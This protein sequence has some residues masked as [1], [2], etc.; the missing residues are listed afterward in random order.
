MTSSFPA[1]Q[2]I[3]SQADAL[4]Q[5]I[6]WHVGAGGGAL[7]QAATLLRSAGQIVVVAIGASYNAAIP[8]VYRLAAAGKH[9]VLEDASEFLHYT[10]RAYP[11]GTLF[12][13]ISR[14]GESVEIV[15]ALDLLIGRSIPII[16]VTNEPESALA[17]RAG[18]TLL[19]GGPND[20]LIAAQTYLETLLTLDL[21]AQAALDSLDAAAFLSQLRALPP[22]ARQVIEYCRTQKTAAYGFRDFRSIYLLGRGPSLASAS[23]AMLMFHEMARYP[24][25]AYPA[26]A[27]RHGPWEVADERARMFVFAPPDSTYDLN[28][29]LAGDLA[30]LRAEVI[31][32]SSQPLPQPDWMGVRLWNLPPLAARWSPYI[33]II[34]LQFFIYEFALWQGLA[35]G[36]FRASTLVTRSETGSLAGSHGQGHETFI[37]E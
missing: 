12:L 27:F 31:L 29:A 22:A 36:V 8:F 15:R 5:S 7:G 18:L 16:G 3:L 33:E 13:L 14:S 21:L 2:N 17:R 20:A 32:L 25:H 10:H 35:P 37:D 24:A 34:P 4:E 9:A 30:R 11:A 26:G 6:D 28:L 1:Y 19:F 23:Q